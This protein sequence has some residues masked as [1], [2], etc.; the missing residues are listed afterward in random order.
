MMAGS[1]SITT[2]Q[3]FLLFLTETTG[4]KPDSTFAPTFA[5]SGPDL[6]SAS[7]LVVSHTGTAGVSELVDTRRSAVSATG[8]TAKH[9]STLT[10]VV[11]DSDTSVSDSQGGT[12]CWRSRLSSGRGTRARNAGN[13]AFPAGAVAT[14]DASI[15]TVAVC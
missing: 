2:A 8:S 7:L 9:D 6:T 15:L 14:F 11:A 1:R 12:C 10:T 3:P 5:K 13:G 4:G